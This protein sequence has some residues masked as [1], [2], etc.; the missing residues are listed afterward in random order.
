MQKPELYFKTDVEWRTWLHDN[1]S[2][3]QKEFTSSSIK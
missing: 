1:H 2:T 3:F